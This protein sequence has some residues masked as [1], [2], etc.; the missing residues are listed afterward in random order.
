MLKNFIQLIG[1]II[2]NISFREVVFLISMM[3]RN[4]V[5]GSIYN[6]LVNKFNGK[7]QIFFVYFRKIWSVG[8]TLNVLDK[9]ILGLIIR[10]EYAFLFDLFLSG[11]SL[12]VQLLQVIT[13][14]FSSNSSSVST[15][16][17][18]GNSV[19]SLTS[20]NSEVIEKKTSEQAF[21]EPNSKDAANPYV[22]E[23]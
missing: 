11:G 15:S 22:S 14:F 1:S 12:S 13:E 5:L 18:L 16:T 7:F 10:V 4:L 17:E 3:A 21:K 8:T 6:L 2:L 9:T 23:K 19:D 20:F